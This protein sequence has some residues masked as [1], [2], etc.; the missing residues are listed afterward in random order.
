MGFI[1]EFL[2]DLSTSQ[3]P[4]I[5]REFHLNTSELVSSAIQPGQK[6]PPNSLSSIIIDNTK[7]PEFFSQ[8]KFDELDEIMLSNKSFDMADFS[9]CEYLV[10]EFGPII[11]YIFFHTAVSESYCLLHIIPNDK[12]TPGCEGKFQWIDDYYKQLYYIN[13]KDII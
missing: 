13:F 8:S 5:F 11:Y 1:V 3:I 6:I 10:F 4:L 2:I 7:K 12:T 9:K